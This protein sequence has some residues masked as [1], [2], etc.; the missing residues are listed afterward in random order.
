MSKEDI[1][2]YIQKH[3]LREMD[4]LKRKSIFARISGLPTISDS[5][6]HAIDAECADRI[7]TELLLAEAV[8]AA[9]KKEKKE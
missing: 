9:A 2:E 8:L 7:N 5:V 4:E 1:L 3:C 6:L